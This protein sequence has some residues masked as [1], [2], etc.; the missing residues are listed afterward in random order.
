MIVRFD[1]ECGAPAVTDVDDAGVF[2]GRHN[3]ALA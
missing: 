1:L 2:A 3:H